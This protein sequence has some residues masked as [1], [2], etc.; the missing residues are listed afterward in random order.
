MKVL[1]FSTAL[2][3]LLWSA[4][5]ALA[6][7]EQHNKNRDND[8]TTHATEGARSGRS[9]MG[10][11]TGGAGSGRSTIGHATGGADSGHTT[12]MEHHGSS[13]GGGAGYS[14]RM[15]GHMNGMSGPTSGERSGRN[16]NFHG[17]NNDFHGGNNNGHSRNFDVHIYQRNF[18]APRHFRVGE[19]RGPRD[20]H[21]R[22]WT[23]GE[24][25]PQIYFSRDYWLMDFEDYGLTPPPPDCVW[26]RYGPDALLIDEYSGEIIQ[27][28]Y[29][30]FY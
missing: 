6:A 24:W 28:E 1:L 13:G 22:R 12:V 18:V 10:S 11:A 21:Y 4:P 27:V 15:S 14:N 19:Y 29:G 16:D 23:Y 5:S 17:R 8:T 30:V 2:A 3:A 26:V 25:L 20:Y 9:T 7:D